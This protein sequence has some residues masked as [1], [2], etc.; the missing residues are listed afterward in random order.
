ME[1]WISNRFAPGFATANE[2]IE[3]VFGDQDG[4]FHRFELIGKDEHEQEQFRQRYIFY[5]NTDFVTIDLK[6]LQ[7]IREVFE[8]NPLLHTLQYENSMD[9]IICATKTMNSIELSVLDP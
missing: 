9:D 2:E 3:I 6:I 8:R 4:S 7:I 1:D 5:T